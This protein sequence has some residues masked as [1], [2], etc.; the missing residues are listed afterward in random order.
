M[1]QQPKWILDGV[2]SSDVA[3]VWGEVWPITKRAVDRFPIPNKFTEDELVEN[4]EKATMQLWVIH[5]A[6]DNRIAA[7]AI[8]SIIEDEYFPGEQVFEVPFVAGYG[9]KYW[10]PTLFTTLKNYALANGCKIMLGYGR[11]G[12][13]R[14]IGFE[15]I[16]YMSGGV[17]VMARRLDEEH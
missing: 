11:V 10:L 12:W 6:E 9:M 17:I 1:M 4:L 3:G 7:V 5:D 15:T 16:G 8:T 13:K 2:L 14:L